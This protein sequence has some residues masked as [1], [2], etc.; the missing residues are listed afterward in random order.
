MTLR[1]RLFI[2]AAIVTIAAVAWLGVGVPMLV[3]MPDDLDVKNAYEGTFTTFVNPSNGDPLDG[4]VTIPLAVDRHVYVVPGAVTANSALVRDDITLRFAD[5]VDEKSATYRID[6]RSLENL[7]DAKT[8]VTDDTGTYSVT[9]PFGASVD[10][11][12][13]MWKAE[14]A[15]AYPLR[16]GSGA[17]FETIDGLRVMRLDAALEAT[18]MTQEATAR[19]AKQGLPLALTA[20]KVVSWLTAAGLDPA[21]A[22]A[23]RSAIPADIPLIYSI[24]T[25]ATANA[26]PKSGMV[27][28]VS[29]AVEQVTVAADEAAVAPVKGA[30]AGNPAL[31]ASLDRLTASRP[32][33]TLVYEQTP[34]SVAARVDAARDAAGSIDMA[35]RNLPAALFTVAVLLALLGFVPRRTK[36]P[37][38]ER[39]A[40][41]AGAGRDLGKA[42]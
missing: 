42:A 7:P 2:A 23:V 3:R 35:R 25:T 21:T 37:A 40:A 12:Y 24:A 31:L 4:P 19:I 9:L 39:V 36:Q 32:V 27:V 20:D 1:P 34:A 26:E 41:P 29:D 8:S 15:T 17:R 10:A 38:D 16:H 33:Y 30:L 6:R 13:R 14:T 22:D 28:R 18:P 5:R 11:T